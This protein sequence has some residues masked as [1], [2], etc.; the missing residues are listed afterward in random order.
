MISSEAAPYWAAFLYLE[1]DRDWSAMSLGMAGSLSLPLRIKRRE[2]RAEGARRGYRG[3]ALADFVEIVVAFDDV[4][5]AGLS[6]KAA[7]DAKAD[8]AKRDRKKR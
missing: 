4:R 5:V 2:I 1:R 6:E 8:T 7:A 3:E